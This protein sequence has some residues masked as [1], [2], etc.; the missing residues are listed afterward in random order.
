MP[1]LTG[2]LLILWW[3]VIVTV[4]DPTAGPDQTDVDIV[5][6]SYCLLTAIIVIDP[7][8]GPDQTDVDIEPK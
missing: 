4:I 5:M 7:A 8:A 3:S 2:L 1:A 6:I